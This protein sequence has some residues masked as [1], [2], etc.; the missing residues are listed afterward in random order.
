M[1]FEDL[2]PRMLQGF[3]EILHLH[4]I[5]YVI[6]RNIGTPEETHFEL[7][8]IK[9]QEREGKTRNYFGFKVGSDVQVNDV[10][11]TEGSASNSNNSP[12]SSPGNSK[13]KWLITEIEDQV[14]GD[15]VIH[16]KAVYQRYQSEVSDKQV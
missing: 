13:D 8:G 10:V 4:G 14:E 2:G 15:V 3:E 16:L 7:K 5:T 6:I 11:M 9:N 1:I 12:D